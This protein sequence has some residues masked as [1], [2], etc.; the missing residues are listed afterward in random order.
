MS[1]EEYLRAM[2]VEDIKGVCKVMS[3]DIKSLNEKISVI[4]KN[5]KTIKNNISNIDISTEDDEQSEKLDRILDIQ[6][7]QEKLLKQ[8]GKTIKELK[9]LIELVLGQNKEL[10]AITD[11]LS[12]KMDIT[13]V[14]KP[15]KKVKVETYKDIHEYYTKK[16]RKSIKFFM[17]NIPDIDKKQNEANKVKCKEQISKDKNGKYNYSTNASKDIMS[18]YYYEELLTDDQRIILIE[19]FNNEI[20]S[21]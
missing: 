4:D 19:R 7:D 16:F 3:K 2:A 8:Q 1:T 13:K 10:I 15:V 18:K 12:S 6:D 21:T 14:E 20:K 9:K 17:D 11:D 5:V